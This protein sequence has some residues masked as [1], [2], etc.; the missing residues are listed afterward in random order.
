MSLKFADSDDDDHKY[1][2]D[3][4]NCDRGC[5]PIS[6]ENQRP[7]TVEQELGIEIALRNSGIIRP[8]LKNQ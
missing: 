2:C 8:D 4:F 7:A 6:A 5:E 1:E 3:G